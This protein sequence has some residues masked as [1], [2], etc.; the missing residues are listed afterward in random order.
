MSKYSSIFTV[1]RNYSETR[2]YGNIPS[3][4][5]AVDTFR[6]K[7]LEEVRSM[8]AS[9]NYWKVWNDYRLGVI[10][11]NEWLNHPVHREKPYSPI[12]S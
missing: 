10:G 5:P 6:D 8:L 2:E 3:C 12:L 4:V 11:W 7:S 1:R 9:G